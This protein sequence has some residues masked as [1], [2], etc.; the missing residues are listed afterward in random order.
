MHSAKGL[1]WDAVLIIDLVEDRF[2]SRH[3]S[4]RAEEF[5]EERRLLYVACTRARNYLGLFVP[6][7]VYSRE[8]KGE[9]RA[10]PSPFVRALSPALYEEFQECP[11]GRLARR[12][13]QDRTARGNLRRAMAAPYGKGRVPEHGPFDA[14]EAEREP[15]KR[16]AF[17]PEDDAPPA[18]FGFSVPEPDEKECEAD[19]REPTEAPV[20]TGCLSGT[21][22]TDPSK[23]GFCRHRIFG[24]GKIVEHIPPDKCRV[25]FPNIGLKVILTNYLV[26]EDS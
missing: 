13:E 24:R 18:R 2:P 10:T 23:C 22:K 4:L 21:G 1:E 25:H 17:S 19:L 6:G 16:A 3:A 9:E 20:D 5:E 8:T 15:P 26:L 11:G 14:S 7:A 12:K